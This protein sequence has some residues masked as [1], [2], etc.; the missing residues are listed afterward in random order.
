MI[1]DS[2]P[3]SSRKGNALLAIS[4]GGL[5]AGALDLTQAFI[6]FG[7]NVPLAIAGGLLGRAAFRG[8]VGTYVLGVFL[9]FFIAF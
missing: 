4:V 7:W 9:H 6:L 2:V 1:G 3:G 8:G 5:L